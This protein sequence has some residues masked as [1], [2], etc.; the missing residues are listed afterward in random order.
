[1]VKPRAETI[2]LAAESADTGAQSERQSIIYGALAPSSIVEMRLTLVIILDTVEVVMTRGEAATLEVVGWLHSIYDTMGYQ[3]VRVVIAGRDPPAGP[4]GRDLLA[5]LTEIATVHPPIALCDLDEDEG[6]ELLANYGVTDQAVART[7]AAA[8]PRNPL[9]LRIVADAL[10]ADEALAAEVRTAHR[11]ARVDAPSARTYLARRIVAHLADPVARPYLLAAMYLPSITRPQLR[12]ILIPT[13]DGAARPAGRRTVERVFR[14]L[15]SARWLS[16]PGGDPRIF[17]FH[18]DVRALVRMLLAADQ[19]N[20]EMELKL[21]R[22]AVAV[23]EAARTSRDRAY[24]LY[25]RALLGENVPA[26]RG[27]ETVLRHL[28]GVL[29]DL[30]EVWRNNLQG[31][32]RP[33][34]GR[35]DFVVQSSSEEWR[36]YLEGTGSKDGEGARLLKRDRA[37]QA[38]QFYRER[39][40]Q[41][42][43]APPTFVIRALADLGEWHTEEVDD[44]AIL[45]EA[46]YWL[47]AKR[48][49]GA[50]MSRLYWLTRFGLLRDE[51]ELSPRH[52]SI[53]ADSCEKLAGA[54]LSTIPALV[55]VAEARRGEAIMSDQMRGGRG[56]IESVTRV[57]LVNARQTRR[58]VD[59]KPHVDALVVVQRDWSRRIMGRAAGMIDVTQL[60]WA[61][62]TLDSLNEAP[63]GEM[64]RRLNTLRRP[65]RV[66]WDGDDIEAGILLLRGQTTEFLR[67]VRQALLD[68]HAR[69]GTRAWVGDL[70]R[71]LIGR[72][73]IRPRELQS[74]L[75]FKHL[76]RDPGAWLAAIVGFADRSRLL[77]YL[78]DALASLPGNDPQVVKAR[79]IARSFLAWDLAICD[80]LRSGWSGETRSR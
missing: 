9:L 62:N 68:L 35:H 64:N 73:S 57:H 44:E 3:D 19:G 55:A 53:L 79:N 5:H 48:L 67:P 29:D 77:P 2:S 24:G 33:I 31:T 20:R 15:R 74:D 43:G 70:L 8:V 42:P 10:G 26:L 34:A 17:S 72:M 12:D 61:Q 30:P 56:A 58:P 41:R 22:R 80:G 21:R 23:H 60:Q 32:A 65:V 1:M 45:D 76:A 51:G 47:A 27:R 16:R 78:C 25:H 66:T 6:A 75:F 46:E 7:A 36:L 11:E 63:L 18:R 54:T 14:A 39:P 69:D 28:E 4:D 59:F 49:S 37:A 71:G 38:L 13:V 52:A 50:A 40:T